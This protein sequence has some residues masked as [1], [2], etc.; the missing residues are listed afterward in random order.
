MKINSLLAPAPSPSPP[1]RPPAAPT[2]KGRDV[3]EVFPFDMIYEILLRLPTTSLIRFRRVCKKWCGIIDSFSFANEHVS[4][5]SIPAVDE[6]QIVPMP[7]LAGDEKA[8]HS[9]ICD[10]NLVKRSER[11]VSEFYDRV[12]YRVSV[13]A[14]GLVLFVDKAD[15]GN[16]CLCNPL[17]G[18]ILELPRPRAVVSHHLA[19]HFTCFGIGF[20]SATNTYK[21]VRAYAQPLD[22]GIFHLIH[23]N[24]FEAEVYT[25]GTRS[26]R[27]VSLQVLQV[28]FSP[29]CLSGVSAY[30]D[31]H[32]LNRDRKSKKDSIISFDF[33]YQKDYND[34]Q[35]V[36]VEGLL[37]IVSYPSD[38]LIDIWML[39]DYDNKKREYWVREYRVST[40]VW[41]KQ[42]DDVTVGVARPDICFREDKPYIF[43]NACGRGLVF[44]AFHPK[45]TFVLD[46]KTQRIW[47]VQCPFPQMYRCFRG[48]SSYTGSPLS[49]RYFGNHV[50]R[51][52]KYSSWKTV[53]KVYVS[54]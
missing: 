38:T 20:D 31:T 7:A 21:I 36:T 8:L 16:I 34:F 27:P 53:R 51:S 4:A 46:L 2:L 6:P 49:L 26:W 48:P 15:Q 1:P 22:D 41:A 11:P 39:K 14:H 33:G 52:Q 32:W 35:L 5:R 19:K 43:A 29:S 47:Y 17:R 12:A 13:I 24:K 37:A 9:F 10:V 40:Q 30:G 45:R 54:P 28:S 44:T 42:P 3:E 18:E 25:L 23:F 50:K